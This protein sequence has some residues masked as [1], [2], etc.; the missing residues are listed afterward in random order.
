M[1]L[2]F[3]YCSLQQRCNKQ[4]QETKNIRIAMQSE[5]DDTKTRSQ[6][7]GK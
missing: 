7:S 1:C 4:L 2:S 5:A 3:Y 6:T